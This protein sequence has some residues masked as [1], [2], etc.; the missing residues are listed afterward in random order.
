[1]SLAGTVQR[2]ESLK[3]AASFA[4]QRRA[5]QRIFQVSMLELGFDGHGG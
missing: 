3:A 5:L 2:I 4:E 1:V